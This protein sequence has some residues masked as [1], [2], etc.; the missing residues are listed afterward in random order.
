MEKQ[1][2]K[3]EEQARERESSSQAAKR[4]TDYKL[5]KKFH[6]RRTPTTRGETDDLALQ[7]LW[8][9]RGRQKIGDPRGGWVGQRPKKDQGHFP[10]RYFLMVFSNSPR[11]ET[12]KNVIKKIEIFFWFWIFGKK[13]QLFDTIFCKRFFVVFL[14]SIAA[15]H[16]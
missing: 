11:R 5:I 12:P 9:P 8:A 7:L 15:K 6:P 4:S 10:F 16:P 14:N 13:T 2:Y 1:A 3:F